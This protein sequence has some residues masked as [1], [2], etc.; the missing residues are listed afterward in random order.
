MEVQDKLINWLEQ[1]STS[2]TAINALHT[3]DDKLGIRTY[4]NNQILVTNLRKV[5][6]IL[7][8]PYHIAPCAT[9]SRKRCIT[10]NFRGMELYDYEEV[11]NGN[12]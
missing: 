6:E 2:Y 5:C 1:L 8:M 10:A 9:D 3:F 12:D 4:R 7:A 11:K